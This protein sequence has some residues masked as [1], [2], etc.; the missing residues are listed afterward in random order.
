MGIVN[1]KLP[2]VAEGIDAA[3]ILEWKVAVGERISEHQPLVEVETDKAVVV[4]P[5]PTHG[6]VESLCFEAGERAPVGAV[7]ARFEVPAG[8]D[9][10]T[11]KVEERELEMPDPPD[12]TPAKGV[13]AAEPSPAA[14][15]DG[16]APLAS[17]ATR[18]LARESGVDL[19][20]VAG[21]GPNGR[22]S[23]QDV[24]THAHAPTARATTLQPL[25]LED[26]IVPLR[27]IRRSIAVRLSKAWQEVPHVIDYREV[28]ATALL[29]ARDRLRSRAASREQVGV[30]AALTITPILVKLTCQ[31]LAEHPYVNA[32]IDMEAE[33]IRLHGA[34]HVGVATSTEEGL[35]VPVI[36]DAHEKTI[37]EIALEIAELASAA[38]ERR[39]KPDQLRGATFTVNNFGGLGIWLGTPIISPPQVANLGIGRLQERVVALGGEAVIR[40]ILT[41]SVSGDHRVLDG[42][43]LASFVSDV[44]EL[45][46]EPTLLLGH[47]R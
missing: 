47:G 28:D 16:R 5:C 34:I 10:E 19:A 17:P 23:R 37:V 29:V 2:D 41:L 30:A 36:H 14:R 20:E 15:A 1:F 22:I 9:E 44:C 25:S 38:R 39:L 43:T 46:L 18:K 11:D 31:A 21:S 12:V 32:S 4:V 6:L 7:I 27:G 24:E 40:K 13:A 33:E 35:M 42:S 45:I 26:R 3:E 8:G